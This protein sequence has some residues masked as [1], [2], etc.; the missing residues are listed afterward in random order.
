MK[1]ADA[2][3]MSNHYTYYINERRFQREEQGIVDDHCS[4]DSDPSD[5]R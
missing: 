1:V 4:D 5:R 2:A 3:K